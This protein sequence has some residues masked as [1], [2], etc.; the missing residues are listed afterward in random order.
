MDRAN[1]ATPYVALNVVPSLFLKHVFSRFGMDAVVIGN[2]V[3]RR[4]F[5]YRVRDLR[6]R[7]LTL[8]STRNFEPVYNVACTLRAFA[9]VQE[10]CPDAT[11]TLVGS[12]SQQQALET[13]AVSLV[14]LHG[15]N[16]VGSV[17]PQEVP[18]D[19]AIADIY[20]QDPTADNMPLSVLE[21]FASGL[22]VRSSG[23]R[24]CTRCPRRSRAGPA[25]AR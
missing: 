8:L 16:F 5:S 13:L 11:L 4:D 18:G 22:P 23:G 2:T 12:G 21:A 15:V 10:H 24:R 1:G 14:N 6:R 7:P 19:C 17:V 20:V 9:L 3:D 25:G